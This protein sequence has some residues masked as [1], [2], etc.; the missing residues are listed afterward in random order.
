MLPD[1]LPAAADQI[2]DSQAIALLQQ[3]QRQ[4][5]HVDVSQKVIPIDTAFIHTDISQLRSNL[6]PLLFIHGFDSSLLEFRRIW[7]LLKD[8]Q[9]I[10]AID[11]YGAGF[12]EFSPKIPVNPQTIRLH[13][14]Q[15]IA[16]LINKPVILIGAS[17]GGAVAIDLALHY[18][19]WIRAIVLIDSVGFSGSF[20][21][22]E[23][24]P[25]PVIQVGTG[26]LHFRK[27]TALTAATLLESGLGSGFAAIAPR[28]TDDLRC[29]LLHQHMPGWSAATLS[30]T[31]SGGYAR[32]GDRVSE[33]QPPTLILWGEADPILGTADA[34]KFRQVIPQ[35]ELIWI[36][37][38]GH[39]PHL[40]QPQQVS[41]RI[42]AFC[43]T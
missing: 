22:G 18:P 34:Q 33:L 31:R 15:T 35:S 10:W 40:D 23:F 11:L 3:I 39:A 17:L 9:N 27:Q 29:S 32:I 14:L 26:W 28:L 30:F 25:E 37:Q 24:L 4:I 36:R 41:D 2:C 12:T 20:P 21:I 6:S 19:E 16:M 7:P 1:F 42:L 43:Q 8:Q 13:L 5:I 38:A